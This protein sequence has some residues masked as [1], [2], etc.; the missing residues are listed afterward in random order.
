MN[1]KPSIGHEA[2]YCFQLY[3]LR[4]IEDIAS[5]IIKNLPIGLIDKTKGLKICVENF[6][7]RQ[8]LD[9]L[10]IENR[11]DL[12]G[13]YQGIPYSQKSIN[14]IEEDALFLYRGPIIRYTQEFKE[15]IESVIYQIIL[16]EMSHHF[17]MSAH[18]LNSAFQ[19]RDW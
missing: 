4:C 14:I 5:S 9:R 10:K 17:R 2:F 6:A 13:L 18:Q 16:Q 11:Y 12:L 19:E 15:D 7:S 1:D 8:T 3:S